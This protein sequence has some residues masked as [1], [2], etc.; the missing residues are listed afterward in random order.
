MV[1]ATYSPKVYRKD[2]G[3]TQVVASGGVIAIETGGD[4]TYNGDSLIDEIAA[5]SGLD[6]GEVGVLNGVTP[7]T[8][9]ASKAAVLD[10][11]GNFIMPATGIFGLS[12]AALAAAGTDATNGG[13]VATQVVAVTA[14]DGTKGVVLPAA[15]VALGPILIINTVLTTGAS[16]K[17]YPVNGGNDLINGEAEDLPFTMGPGEAA[18]FIPTSA[19]QWYVADKSGNLLTKTE[20]NLLV[21]LLATAA[22]IN[23]AAD[24]STRI[25]VITATGAITEADHEGKTC[26]LREAGGNALVTL[27]LPA[28]TGGGGRYRFVVDEVNTSNYV[29]KSVAG[30][31][32]MRGTI[33]GASITDSATEAARTWT[34]GA[35]DDTLTLNGTTMGGVTRGDWVEFED[36]AADGWAVRGVITQSGSE[37]T[38]FSD[39]V[40]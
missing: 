36:I 23:R 40:A 15:A 22:E 3:D 35:T 8:G 1:D 29:F 34:A 21:G 11:S 6:S 31:D 32:V 13:A 33:I 12:R 16:L 19:T 27:T 39:T 5:L 26:L 4:I 2:G 25:V 30:A 24:L 28:A 14:S 20:E 18:W 9:A 7:G 10:A 17:V 37:V 38:P